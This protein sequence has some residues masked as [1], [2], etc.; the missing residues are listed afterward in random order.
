MDIN[1]RNVPLDLHHEFKIFAVSKGSNIKAEILRLM[2]E[3][4]AQAGQD[5]RRTTGKGE[6]S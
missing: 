5:K 3:A 4:L 6:R 2:C 1:L